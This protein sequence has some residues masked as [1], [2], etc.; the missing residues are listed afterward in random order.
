MLSILLLLSQLSNPSWMPKSVGKGFLG[1]PQEQNVS[2]ILT[3]LEN[4]YGPNLGQLSLEFIIDWRVAGQVHKYYISPICCAMEEDLYL[5]QEHIWFI[6]FTASPHAFKPHIF[7]NFGCCG[8]TL[9]KAK[10][11]HQQIGILMNNIIFGCQ[12]LVGIS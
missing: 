2:T 1:R 8:H 6:P 3:I 4:L 5:F 9:S 7:L 10:L 12:N 11:T